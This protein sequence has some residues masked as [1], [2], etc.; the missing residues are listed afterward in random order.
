MN[1]AKIQDQFFEYIML[2]FGPTKELEKKIEQKFM[3]IKSTLI[4]TFEEEGFVPHVFTYG[5][6]PMKSFIK[7]SDLDITIIL[8][9]VKTNTIVTDYSADELEKFHSNKSGLSYSRQAKGL[10]S[11]D[12]WFVNNRLDSHKCG[13]ETSKDGV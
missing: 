13:G 6:F 11:G 2:L 7:N 8:E 9:N 4:K 1:K 10:Q 5:S 12:G 3:I